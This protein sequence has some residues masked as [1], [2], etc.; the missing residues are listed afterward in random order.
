MDTG[1]KPWPQAV[2]I[3][4]ALMDTQYW[5]ERI[6]APGEDARILA[7]GE[8]TGGSA[9]N[10]A[11]GMAWLGVPC[12]FCGCI[13]P[14]ETGGRIMGMLERTGVDTRLVRRTG[15]TGYV[16]SMIDPSGERTMFSYRGASAQTDFT[17]QLEEALAGAKVVLLSGYMLSNPEQAGFALQAMERARAGGAKTALDAS[18]IFGGL[19]EETRERALALCDIFMPN[20]DEL[21]MAGP[22]TWQ[23]NLE[24]LA[25]RIPC[26]AVKLGGGGALLRAAPGFSPGADALRLEVGTDRQ[27][28]LDTTGAGDAF[29]AG[30]LAAY[31]RGL[32]PEKWLESGN[33]LAGKVIATKGATGLYNTQPPPVSFGER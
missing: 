12:G 6:P 31:L 16:L 5:V 28:P 18:P 13:G 32:P 7:C 11:I 29:N 3:G 30:F 14:D 15:S 26:V 22:G 10:S 27:S 21:A 24:Q 9:A 17:P 2:T 25:S 23:E 1:A 4:D 20:R 33:W 19:S 8:N